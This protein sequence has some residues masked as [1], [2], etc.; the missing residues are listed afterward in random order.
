[1]LVSEL[2]VIRRF[3]GALGP[4]PSPGGGGG[5]GFFPDAAETTPRASTRTVAA[6]AMRRTDM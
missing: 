1:M 4:P 5:D 3:V 6:K 2:A